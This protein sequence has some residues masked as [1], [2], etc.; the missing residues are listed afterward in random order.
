M[1]KYGESQSEG[2]LWGSSQWLLPSRDNGQE[3][4]WVLTNLTSWHIQDPPQQV[5]QRAVLVQVLWESK[6]TR[7]SACLLYT[8]VTGCLCVCDKYIL[9]V[10]T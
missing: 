3:K 7:A 8:C 10:Y 2:S 6:P 9:P 4:G 1:S 5:P